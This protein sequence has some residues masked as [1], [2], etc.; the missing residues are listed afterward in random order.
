MSLDDETMLDPNP[1]P[2][3]N[4]I[5]KLTHSKIIELTDPSIINHR[6]REF[7]FRLHG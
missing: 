4:N 7:R 6:G 2:P 5:I 1:P 3:V